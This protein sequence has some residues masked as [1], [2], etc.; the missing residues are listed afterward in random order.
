MWYIVDRV[1]QVVSGPYDSW[2]S[3]NEDLV[4]IG[5]LGRTYVVVRS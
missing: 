4:S 1:G 3:A 5:S 2:E